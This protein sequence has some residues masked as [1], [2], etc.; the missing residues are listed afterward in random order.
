MKNLE[1]QLDTH[2]AAVYY[3]GGEPNLFRI[4]VDVTPS[5]LKHKL[6]QLNGRLHRSA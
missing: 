5:D 1:F 2:L 3:N 6:P 4:H